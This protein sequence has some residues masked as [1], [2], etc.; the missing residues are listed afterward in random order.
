MN[1]NYWKE[2]HKIKFP[3]SNDSSSMP[4]DTNRHD[5]NLETGLKFLNL[6]QGEVL[7][8]GCGVGNDASY[9]SNLGFNVDAI[10][11]NPYFINKAKKKN[12]NVNFICGNV[13]EN[14]PQKKYDLIYDRGFLHNVP[15][16]YYS[17]I[18]NLLKSRLNDKGYLILITGHPAPEKDLTPIPTPTPYYEIILGFK[19]LFNIKMI[20]EINFELNE[21]FGVREGIIYILKPLNINKLC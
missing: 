3:N 4:W 17:N 10:D 16:V 1:I 15:H 19:D 9:L 6:E 12:L 8:L 21:N 18:F 20:K 7:E 5:I 13:F 11:I 14:L 2:V